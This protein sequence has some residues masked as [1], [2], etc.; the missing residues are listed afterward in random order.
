MEDDKIW[1]E[2]G[3]GEPVDRA[4]PKQE[5]SAR[6]PDT[7]E[8]CIQSR[9]TNV[10]AAEEFAC[11]FSIESVQTANSFRPASASIWRERVQ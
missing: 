4:T 7:S 11:A 2:W 9:C 1:G 5:C 8:R 6:P 10:A 3:G